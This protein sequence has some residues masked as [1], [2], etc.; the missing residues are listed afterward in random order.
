[1]HTREKAG[2]YVGNGLSCKN[3]HLDR[4]RQPNAMPLWGG[5][6]LYPQYREKNKRIIT[7]IERLQ[8]CFLYSMNGK[9]PPI[10]SEILTALEA[11]SHWLSK[12]VK[13][14]IPPE[15]SIFL[16]FTPPEQPNYQRGQTVF[17]AQCAICHSQDGQGQ[18]M[19]KDYLYPPLW[20]KNSYNW[21]AGMGRLD[22]AAGFIK[23]NMPLGQENSLSDQQAWD[24]AFF[25]NAHERPQD[26]RYTGNL[27]ETRAKYH[28][29]PYSLYGTQVNGNLVGLGAND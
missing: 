6:G 11:Y 2:A 19:G 4:G 3:C 16:K 22:T 13:I 5:Y 1:M 9:K 26:P 21:G 12:G 15:G 14:D 17:N 20:G 24:V 23:G 29:T 10:D 8:D 18:K 7:Y 28:N 27:A 25:I